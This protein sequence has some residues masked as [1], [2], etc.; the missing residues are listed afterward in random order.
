MIKKLSEYQETYYESSGKASDVA[1]HLA[2]A[3]IAVIWIFRIEQ[4]AG[5]KIEP[6]LLLPLALLALSLAFD[7]LQYI[8]ATCVWGVFQWHQERNLKNVLDDPDLDT[9][10]YYKWPQ[11]AFFVLKLFTIFLA[12]VFLVK[13]IWCL[14]FES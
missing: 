7:L 6:D 10:A 3:G 1:R 2:F 9:P 12:Y 5:V 11:F 8:S 4:Q 13:Y 14:W